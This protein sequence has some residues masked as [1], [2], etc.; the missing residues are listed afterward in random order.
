[1]IQNPGADHV[2]SVLESCGQHTI[3]LTRLRGSGGM[4]MCHFVVRHKMNKDQGGSVVFQGDLD[5]FPWGH[6]G[7]IQGASE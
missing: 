4:V 1:M 6:A 5:H 7:S 3:G 2:E